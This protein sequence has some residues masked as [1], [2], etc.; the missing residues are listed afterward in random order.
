[1]A[2]LSSKSVGHILVKSNTLFT[3]NLSKSCS[4]KFSTTT[5]PNSV[6]IQPAA[7]LS[8]QFLSQNALFCHNSHLY[9]Q[10]SREASRK[11]GFFSKLYQS[12]RDELE[13]SKEI[14]SS[15][16]KF[17]DETTKL[18]ESDALKNARKKYETFEEETSQ[19]TKVLKEKISDVSG[20][21]KDSLDDIK[22]SELGQQTSNVFENVGK[23]VKSAG[24]TLSKSGKAITESEAFKSVSE[25]SEIV[26]KNIDEELARARVYSSPK[27]LKR[28][29][30]FRMFSTKQAEAFDPETHDLNESELRM[31]LHKDARWYAKWQ[32]FKDTN[33]M[34]NK[35]FD[36]KNQYDESENP[37]IASTRF[38]SEKISGIV[39]GIMTPNSVSKVMSEIRKVDP[40]FTVTRFNDVCHKIIFPHVVEA[41]FHSKFDLLED[42]C[43]AP[44][45]SKI[46]AQLDPLLKQG[47]KIESHIMDVGEPDVETAIMEDSVPVLVSRFNVQ[48]VCTIRDLG[49]KVLSLPEGT[50]L[51]GGGDEGRVDQYM[52]FVA[53]TRDMDDV[54]PISSWRIGDVEIRKHTL[55]F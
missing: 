8:N 1:M 34:M 11:G 15:I 10:F 5:S 19:K 41:L 47:Y 44:A 49:G 24:E 16:K 20:A 45:Y 33:P 23:G 27:I 28:R 9:L 22:K 2:S 42:W 29:S 32:D 3:S 50:A 55:A 6:S 39:G 48:A 12:V 38:L 13:Q 4:K 37:V 17:R 7:R 25:A 21:L 14:K 31:E 51:I 18:D 54:D 52:W 53:L 35:M 46:C 36:L 26:R 40:S 30:D 43:T